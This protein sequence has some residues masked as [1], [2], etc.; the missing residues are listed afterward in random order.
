MKSSNQIQS[1]MNKKSGQEVAKQ[2][3]GKTDARYWHD[4]IFKPIYTRDGKTRCVEDWAARIQWRGRRELFNLKTPNKT[5]AAAKAKEIYTTLV[6][7][8]WDA[9]L[10]KFKPEMQRK[11]VSTVGDFL[12][13]LRGHW[14]GKRKTFEDYC[15]S[16][17]QIVSEIFQIKGGRDGRD[18]FDYIKG[19]RVA[20]IAKIDR[21]KLAD[22]TPDKL[23]KWRI[24]FVKKAGGNPVKQRRARITCNSIMRQAK[25]LFSPDLLEY[26]TLHT[27]DKLPFDG[28]PFYERESQRYRSKI[29]IEALIQSAMREL[30]QE[31]LKI[32]LLA[33]MAGLRRNEI[34]KLQWSAFRW[35]DG[36]I[37]IEEAEHFAAKSSDGAGDVPIDKELLAMFRGWQAKSTGA[38]VI[39]ADAEPRSATTYAHYRAQ[40][41][42]D[43]LT[44][45]LRAKGVTAIKPL[46][47]LRKEFGS[48]VCAKYGIYAASRM[49]RHADIRVTA[50][51]YLDAKKRTPI[52]LG[53]LL[54][55][56][57]NVTPMLAD[58]GP[59]R[60]G[61]KRI[62]K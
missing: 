38:F 60:A 36:V 47:E 43:L 4:V 2:S 34:D 5:A 8:G 6:G 27:P 28:V 59:K 3:F 42:F 29:D 14:S 26:V 45:W 56:P 61:V 49:L 58:S 18:R 50:Q 12:T 33:T 7:A 39:E 57:K 19:G 32:F 51:H 54:A 46:H 25:S 62:S 24:G 10:E 48:Q 20:W 37:R 17:R 41:D 52:A 13:E 55:M 35:N 40:A 16:F 53:N 1:A 23:N 22:V 9:A 31:Q 44:S 21:I 30:P 15:R 11:S